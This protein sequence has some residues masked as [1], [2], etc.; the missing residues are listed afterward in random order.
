MNTSV[1]S[2]T[3]TR[4]NERVAGFDLLRGICAI[5]V[6]VYHVL[7]WNKVAHLTTW[8]TYAV[9]MF[10]VL[11]GAS[12]WVAYAHRFAAGFSV[13]KFLGLRLVRLLPLYLVGLAL[14]IIYKLRNG[15]DP[16][17]LGSVYLNLLFQFGLGNPGATS[18][19]T[20]GWSLGIEFVFYLLFPVF[21]AVL[22]GR[23][24][25]VALLLTFA[26]QHLFIATVFS[27]GKDLGE[28]FTAYTQF[29]AF[30]FYFT[31]GCVIGKTLAGRSHWLGL[32]ILIGALAVIA[33][34]SSE[35]PLT[36]LTGI[37]LSLLSVLAVAAAAVI[38]FGGVVAEKLGKASYGVYIL[39]PFMAGF[40]K[41]LGPF[42]MVVG[43]VLLSFLVAL[44]MEKWLEPPIQSYFKSRLQ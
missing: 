15:I 27:N 13:A 34:A 33:T 1:L 19:V 17:S 4:A 3:A 40:L 41:P 31:A 36:G 16:A 12:M 6:A 7:T 26:S 32:P 8:G 24:W 38:P 29:L 39:H 37:C 11:S 2:W 43:T 23:W 14:G 35:S 20:G 10:F 5:A 30:V 28:N 42:G 21:L 25:W 18:Q 44:A 9:Y 22:S